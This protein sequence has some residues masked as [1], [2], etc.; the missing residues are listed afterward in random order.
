MEH[1]ED[2]PSPGG[3]LGAVSTVVGAGVKGVGAGVV[4][5]GAGVMGVG[6][7]VKGAGVKLQG[8]FSGF[9]KDAKEQ[10]ARISH[11]AAGSHTSSA[12]PSKR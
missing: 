12:G 5:V 1:E 9:A 6:A 4:G 2:A 3:I 7:G 8:F 10:F 11:S